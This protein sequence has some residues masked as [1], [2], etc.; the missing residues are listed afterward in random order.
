MKKAKRWTEAYRRL[1]YV[2]GKNVKQQ[3]INKI[4]VPTSWPTVDTYNPDGRLTLSYPKLTEPDTWRTVT[5][6]AEIEL[7]LKLRNQKHFS[8][9]EY[10]G[11]PF[12]QEPLQTLFN[13][14]ASTHQAK[15]VLEGN[16]R[17]FQPGPAVSQG[18]LLACGI[19]FESWMGI[20]FVHTMIP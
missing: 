16:Y 2:T 3:T 12:T 19:G 1:D 15:L 11:T 7:M 6:P 17:A 8:Q 10:E 20:P 13:W 18:L 14:S 4:L 5:C 9:A